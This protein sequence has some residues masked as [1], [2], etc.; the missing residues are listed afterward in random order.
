MWT[1][2]LLAVAAFVTFG[3]VLAIR[4][5]GK[6]CRRK[7]NEEAVVGR[8][9]HPQTPF[10]SREK[11]EQWSANDVARFFVA[12]GPLCENDVDF[13]ADASVSVWTRLADYAQ[14]HSINGLLLVAN[15]SCPEDL[16]QLFGNL[17]PPLQTTDAR[18]VIYV[19]RKGFNESYSTT[20]E[21]ST[22][23]AVASNGGPVNT[24]MESLENK[25]TNDQL[26]ARI[27]NLRSELSEKTAALEAASLAAKKSTSEWSDVVAKLQ[28]E[29]EEK[30][31]EQ[32]LSGT[33][34]NAKM[35]SIVEN[36]LQNNFSCPITMDVLV[37]PVQAGDHVFERAAIEAWLE[38]SE[39]HPLSRR[40]LAKNDLKRA[41][42][43]CEQLRVLEAAILSGAKRR[44]MVADLVEICGLVS[45]PKYNGR[46]G[47]IKHWDESR[48]RWAVDIQRHSLK[49]LRPQNLT[50]VLPPWK[51][52]QKRSRHTG[53]T[54]IEESFWNNE[55]DLEPDTG[56]GAAAPDREHESAWDPSA[57]SEAMRELNRIAAQPSSSSS[58]PSRIPT[59][60]ARDQAAQIIRNA[61][62][63][64]VHSFHQFE[65]PA[66]HMLTP[67]MTPNGRFH[68][69]IC[70]E[71]IR[72]GHAMQG[73]RDCDFD[74][75]VAC[76]GKEARQRRA[77]AEQFQ[78]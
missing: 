78:F 42:T 23:P 21:S 61:A 50:R 38:T 4:A 10:C 31:N 40:P 77:L 1:E 68:C 66:G 59:A 25:Q 67:F 62:G 27:D 47:I 54:G 51:E 63:E 57:L 13:D 3:C 44:L 17:R 26:Q 70:K 16:Q 52:T 30:R 33:A 45:Q 2:I 37:D 46:T 15:S 75:C 69:D 73:C 20:F 19:L 18:A 48:R 8:R 58:V 39:S 29:L 11:V 65:C 55:A 49:F 6:C 7:P 43:T 60:I 36:F 53:S 28:A 35:A 56:G 32:R 22:A 12:N 5:L 41:H 24:T 9:S 71:P 76:T 34:N 64:G 14:Q 74:I 72:Q